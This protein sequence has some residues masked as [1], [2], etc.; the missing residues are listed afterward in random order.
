MF[1]LVTSL[2]TGVLISIGTLVGVI[3]VG[4]LSLESERNDILRGQLSAL[5]SRIANDK[6]QEQTADVVAQAQLNWQ[7]NDLSAAEKIWYDQW[8]SMAA[9]WKTAQHK[10]FGIIAQN[11]SA[12]YMDHGN[13]DQALKVYELSINYDK[14][15][16]GENS[17]E[18]ARDLNNLAL[19]LYLKGTTS[20]E[21]DIR[22]KYFQ[23]AVNQLHASNVLW[24][25]LRI[26][27]S[28]FNIENNN[29][30]RS[31]VQRDLAG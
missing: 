4:N 3:N 11:L 19:C 30:L 9:N 14:K 6:G 8:M 21:K 17:K 25:K 31:I 1:R 28:E 26:K 20:T 12:V 29:K 5:K 10:D 27:Q 18:V 7:L 13:F 23:D 2:L 24:N 16:F 22:A 15:L